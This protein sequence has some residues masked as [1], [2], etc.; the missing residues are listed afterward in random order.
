MGE[1][2]SPGQEVMATLEKIAEIVAMDRENNR[3]LQEFLLQIESGQDC[4]RT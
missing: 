2:R 3:H 1:L 4:K